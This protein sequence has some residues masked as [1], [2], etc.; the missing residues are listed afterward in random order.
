[1]IKHISDK[2]K[3][4]IEDW[5]DKAKGIALKRDKKKMKTVY[6]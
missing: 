4:S 6:Y 5:E 3:I 2:I 1:M